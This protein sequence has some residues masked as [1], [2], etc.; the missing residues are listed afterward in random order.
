MPTAS[1]V[2]GI[3]EEAYD[4][5]VKEDRWDELLASYARLV[6]ADSGLIY[7]RPRMSGGT[8]I[9]S[10]DYDV[11]SKLAK[12]LSYYEARS[13]LLGLYREL[14]EAEISAL[15]EFA[16][17]SD[18][19][20]TE[21]YQDWVRPQG[22]ADLL[23][24]HLVRTPQLYAWLALRRSEQRGAYTR[25]EVLAAKRVAPHLMR[26]IKLRSRLEEERCSA[27]RLRGTLDMLRFGILVVDAS[28]KVL[29]ANR[30]ADSILRTG[31]G[32]RCR[33]G[34]LACARAQETSAVHHAL[35][36]LTQT[37]TATDLYVSRSPGLRP[38][39][40][41]V[42]PISSLSAWSG[43]APPSGIAAVFVMDPTS[44]SPNIDAFA[45]M[46]ALTASESRVL[47]E[48]V[49]CGGLVHAAEKLKVSVPTAR[50]HL[51]SVFAKTSTNNQAE[52]VQLVTR[53][54]LQLN[55]AEFAQ[56]AFVSHLRIPS[57]IPR[58]E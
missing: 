37:G 48:I 18:Y 40:L 13:P 9:A 32:L 28:A 43:F 47:R 14:S 24:T 46:Y 7:L 41:H 12:Y 54:T 21:Y 17:S 36:V 3:I 27:G 38:L 25:P 23:G 45:A 50:T 58:C 56:E 15:G 6:G 4:C 10:L 35:R 51:Q 33:H 22:Y 52:L 34:R 1:T 8:L 42:M 57:P 11:S 44:S 19:R 5:V 39:T 2:D 16:F 29:M 31:D 30:T 53:S 49:A 26:A 20:R 55:G